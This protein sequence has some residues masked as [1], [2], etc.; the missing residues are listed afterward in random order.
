SNEDSLEA[1]VKSINYCITMCLKNMI[2][3]L[4][5]VLL[6]KPK[7]SDVAEI[8]ED[9]DNEDSNLSNNILER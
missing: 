2:L 7:D 6:G 8:I 5:M 4:L 3:I 9:S 1:A